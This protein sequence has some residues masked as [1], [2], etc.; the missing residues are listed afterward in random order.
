[1]VAM[2]VYGLCSLGL[3]EVYN[4]AERGFKRLKGIDRP[5]QQPKLR[6]RVLSY[7]PIE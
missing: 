3:D 5:K 7:E 6:T 2:V 1:M 4:A